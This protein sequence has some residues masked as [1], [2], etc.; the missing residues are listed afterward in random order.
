[1]VFRSPYCS[2]MGIESLG[3][4]GFPTRNHLGLALMT[5]PLSLGKSWVAPYACM[6]H[7]KPS[8]CHFRVCLTTTAKSFL[9]DFVSFPSSPMARIRALSWYQKLECNCSSLLAAGFNSAGPE[10]GSLSVQQSA[11]MAVM[12]MPWRK[13]DWSPGWMYLTRMLMKNSTF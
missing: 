4:L 10:N 6:S 12:P 11:V 1:M 3:S 7:M 9:A 13:N 8:G 2:F 5:D